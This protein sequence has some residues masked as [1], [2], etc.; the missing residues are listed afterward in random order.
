MPSVRVMVGSAEHHLTYEVTQE[1]RIFVARC[2]DFE[3]TSD[4]DTLQEA[5]ANLMEALELFLQDHR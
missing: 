2:L 5:E 3:V 4:G 1:D